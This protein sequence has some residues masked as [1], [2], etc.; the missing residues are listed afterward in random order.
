MNMFERKP[1]EI[2]PEIAE[3]ERLLLSGELRPLEIAG[4]YKM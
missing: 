4:E 1:K 2:N 3:T